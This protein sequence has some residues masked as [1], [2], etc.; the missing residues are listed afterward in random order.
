M[1]VITV[2]PLTAEEAAARAAWLL[3][4]RD[5]EARAWRVLWDAMNPVPR[6]PVPALP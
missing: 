1:Q 5:D 6:E 3:A 4:D 2:R